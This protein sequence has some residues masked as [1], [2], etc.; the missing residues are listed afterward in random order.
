MDRRY[1]FLLTVVVAFGVLKGTTSS[2]IAQ[3]LSRKEPLV[4]LLS[5]DV[6]IREKIFEVLYLPDEELI[7]ELF[8]WPKFNQMDLEEKG[9]FLQ[10]IAIMRQKVRQ[11]A[12]SKARQL[13]LSLNEEQL[14]AFEK[15]YWHKRLEIEKK[16][17]EETENRRK[18]L[19]KE[20]EDA[21]Q[22][23]FSN[24]STKSV[25]ELEAHNKSH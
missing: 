20:L 16:F 19:A 17:I 15:S 1:I 9:W 11:L 6:E 10:R 14:N 5:Q 24:L 13:G 21:L 25:M 22:K 3:V 8:K 2:A 18:E 7:K 23:E 4:P 12:R